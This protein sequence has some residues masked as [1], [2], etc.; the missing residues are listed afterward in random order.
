MSHSFNAALFFAMGNIDLVKT[1]FQYLKAEE[2]S[3]FYTPAPECQ[4]FLS[5]E[6]QRESFYRIPVR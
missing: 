6:N 1:V 3:V 4:T 5:G 2:L